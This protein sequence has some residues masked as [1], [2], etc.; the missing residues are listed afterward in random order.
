MARNRTVYAPKY[1]PLV[2]EEERR[3]LVG[4]RMPMAALAAA[5]PVGI[6]LRRTPFKQQTKQIAQAVG[7][8]AAASAGSFLGVRAIKNARIRQRQKKALDLSPLKPGEP[9]Q[10]GPGG[11]RGVWRAVGAKSLFIEA[12][13]KL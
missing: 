6:L 8:G 5:I 12:K 3:D 13:P 4:E 10:I 9:L 1:Q 2:T 7:L 11:R